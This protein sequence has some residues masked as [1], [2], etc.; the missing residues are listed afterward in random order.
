MAFGV[1]ETGVV[2]ERSK[3]GASVLGE[4]IGDVGVEASKK[5]LRRGAAR[6]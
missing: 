6:E 2:R 5:E 4:R 3:S 1:E